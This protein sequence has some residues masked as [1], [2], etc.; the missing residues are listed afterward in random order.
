MSTSETDPQVEALLRQGIDAARTGDKATA[1]SLLEQVV[2]RDQYSEKGWFWLAAVVDTVE[3][4]RVCLGNVVVINPNN[5]RAS[6]LLEQLEGT[7]LR[8][9]LAAPGQPGSVSRRTAYLAIGLGALAVLALLVVLLIVLGGGDDEVPPDS[10]NNIA[11]LNETPVANL[12][13]DTTESGGTD[14]SVTTAP[15]RTPP[16]TWTPVPIPTSVEVI[17]A[18]PLAAPPADLPGL[19]IM[20]SG[21]VGIDQE[22]HP[23]VVINPDGSNRRVLTPDT[24]RGRTP[25][26]S[27]DGSLYAYIKFA[28]GTR[29]VILQTNNF[30]GT[31]PKWS[32]ARWGGVPILIEQQ[33][34]DWSP[35]G[36]WIAFTAV[37]SDSS[38]PNLYMVSM[39]AEDGSPDA[40]VRV[41]NDEATES[42]PTFSPNSEVI[43]YTASF[44]QGDEAVTDL[45]LYIREDGRITDL[46]TNG[47]ELIEAAPDWSPDARYII[48]E[49]QEAG[50]TQRDIY[51]ISTESESTR[52]EKIIESDADDIRPRFSPDGRYIVF[53][54]NRTGNWDVFIYELAT[55]TTYQVT[56]DS[57]PDIANDWGS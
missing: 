22:N 28:T 42:W 26:L 2:E 27:P 48:F 21:L 29:E 40:L 19:I 8:E 45:R 9:Q 31:V 54:S 39:T 51:R 4:K 43:A 15:S 41:T 17:P 13:D 7:D 12:P 16:P 25:I 46:T 6:R 52:P 47:A 1:R 18:T 23:I 5:R 14:P 20:E 55:E 44:M 11:Q 30:E 49:A 37:G 53:S 56:T 34:P 38:I 35:D 3:E 36:N 24:E 32:S 10:N 57:K 33:M 50:A